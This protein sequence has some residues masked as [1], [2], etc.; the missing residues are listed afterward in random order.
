MTL[1]AEGEEPSMKLL[2]TRKIWDKA[3]H[4]AFTDLVRHRARWWCGFREG[5]AHVSAEGSLR[6]ITSLDGVQWESAAL[7]TSDREDLRDAKLTIAADGRFLLYG[8]G[9]D[10]RKK[11]RVL[12]SYVWTSEDG[13]QWGAGRAIGAVNDWLWRVTR[14]G[15]AYYGIGYGCREIWQG[16]NQNSIRLYKSADGVTFNALVD[17]LRSGD[18][19]NE[20]TIVFRPDGTALCLLR[21]DPDSG[22]LGASM[23]PYREWKWLDIGCR[24][25]GPHM[26][27]LPDGRLLAA[28]RLYDGKTRTS[29]CR[30]DPRTGKLTEALTLPS[31]GDTSY[32]G[33]VLHDGLLWVSYYSSHE[34]KA[35]IYLA[36][37]KIDGWKGIPADRRISIDQS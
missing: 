30:I 26:L 8:A 18:Y 28:V 13:R 33:L 10:Q 22:L 1:G 21:R 11:P 12:R 4:N 37:I 31:G 3:P 36:R 27:F 34:G 20:S 35:A 25:G 32:A 6:V 24:I 5:K 16:G 15:E 29:L 23:P 9:L 17:S 7:L 14:H 19:S 2:E